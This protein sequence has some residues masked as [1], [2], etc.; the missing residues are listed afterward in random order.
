M[1]IRDATELICRSCSSHYAHGPLYHGC[2]RCGGTLFVWVPPELVVESY[3]KLSQW[4]AAPVAELAIP[5]VKAASRL[6]EG[7]TPMPA[8]EELA[9]QLGLG[10][11]W[12]KNETVNPT[13][14]YKDRLNAVAVACAAELG[15]ERLTTSSTGNQAVSLAAYAAAAGLAADVFLPLEAPARAAAEV[16]R[17]GGRAWVTRWELRAPAIRELVEHHGYGY[18]G[19]NCPRPLATHTVSRATR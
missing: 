19:R 13:A 18:V 11:L 12:V 17:T 14:S 9:L 5:G 10:K 16:E 6:G 7:R 3:H 4:P 2:P 1:A 8:Q 15:L